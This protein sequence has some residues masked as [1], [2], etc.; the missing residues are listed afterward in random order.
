MC[1]P[2]LLRP[3]G[4][5]G[6]QDRSLVKDSPTMITRATTVHACRLPT[7]DGTYNTTGAQAS[8][9]AQTLS[10]PKQN[11][12]SGQKLRLA[13]ARSGLPAPPRVL[14]EATPSTVAYVFESQN[15]FGRN[16][17]QTSG[18]PKPGS[19]LDIHNGGRSTS[20]DTAEMAHYLEKLFHT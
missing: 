1:I 19:D 15:G 5:Q 14:Q 17:G 16:L 7:P 9:R 18:S 2:N 4:V 10:R 6:Q 12:S 8:S 3:A 13:R 20:S 11:S